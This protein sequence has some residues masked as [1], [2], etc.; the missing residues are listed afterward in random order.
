MRATKALASLHMCAD[1]P[2]PSLLCK[3]ARAFV[4]LISDKNKLLAR[5]VICTY[6][7]IYAQ[8]DILSELNIRKMAVKCAFFHP[9]H[10]INY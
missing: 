7:I 1:S 5:G 3:L 8:K 4:A 10:I 6:F 2:K 9:I